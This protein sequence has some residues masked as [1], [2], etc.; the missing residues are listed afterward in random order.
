MQQCNLADQATDFVVYQ[1]FRII[2]S[3]AM[4]FDR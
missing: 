4:S 2:L 1:K 3:N